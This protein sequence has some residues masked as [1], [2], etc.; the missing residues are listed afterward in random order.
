MRRLRLRVVPGRRRLRGAGMLRSKRALPL[1]R[2]RR[3]LSQGNPHQDQAPCVHR[4][5]PEVRRGAPPG[6]PRA[7]RDDRRLLPPRGRRRRLRRFRRPRGAD[8]VHRDRASDKGASRPCAQT[9]GFPRTS[10]KLPENTKCLRPIL[11]ESAKRLLRRQRRPQ[12]LSKGIGV[13]RSSRPAMMPQTERYLAFTHLNS[14]ISF[15]YESIQLRPAGHSKSLADA[16]AEGM[17]PAITGPPMPPD[18]A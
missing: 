7:Q 15:C 2:V 10:G 17:A 13:E 4:V 14:K 3:A 16:A 6:L 18:A 9:W 1:L 11:P 8:R 5:R 12:V